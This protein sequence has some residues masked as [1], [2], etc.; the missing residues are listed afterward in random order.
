MKKVL[1]VLLIASVMSLVFATASVSRR[2]PQQ[3]SLPK[4]QSTAVVPLTNKDV[5][6]M[7]QTGL[8]PDIV[9]AKINASKCNFDTSPATLAELKAGGTP[10]SVIMA[11]VQ[12][13]NR[14]DNPTVVVKEELKG[15]EVTVPDG[16][17]VSVITIDE[18][19]SK[20]ASE[21]DA[22]TFK[23]DEDVVVNGRVVI[24]KGTIAKGSVSDVAKSGHMGKGGK[25]GIRLES[26]TTVDSQ[27]IKL[28]ASKGKEGDDKT[29]SVIALTL[30][31]SPFFLLKKGKDAKIKPGTKL[32]AYTD[33]EKKVIAASQSR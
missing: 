20:T 12:A 24:A 13:A 27:K 17:A 26:T 3:Q 19:S 10:E 9:V 6:Q 15:I 14:P 25:L 28:R 23:V 11:M 32:G 1:T 31:V 7:L 29:G 21:G 18:I 16:T 4:E 30:L 33:E 22:L 8:A 5:L 2:S